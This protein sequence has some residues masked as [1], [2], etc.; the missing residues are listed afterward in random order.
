MLFCLLGE[1]RA[2]L[3]AFRA[4]VRFVLVWFCRFSLPHGVWKGLRF[5]IVAIPEI[6]LLPFSTFTSTYVILRIYVYAD[7]IYN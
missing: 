3:G 6:F 5:V 1:E 2:N 4:F 7:R